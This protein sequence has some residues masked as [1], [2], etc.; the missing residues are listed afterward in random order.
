[1]SD[2]LAHQ[3][4]AASMPLRVEAT[5]QLYSKA[6]KKLMVASEQYWGFNKLHTFHFLLLFVLVYFP[7][8]ITKWE[9]WWSGSWH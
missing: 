3:Q 5:A 4:T 8:S 9:Y 1:M 2:P 7:N 6:T